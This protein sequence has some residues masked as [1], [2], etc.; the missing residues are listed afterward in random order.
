M[1]TTL[2]MSF[3]IGLVGGQ[4][5]FTSVD[6]D[7]IQQLPYFIPYGRSCVMFSC[8]RCTSLIGLV[9]V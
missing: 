9:L 4:L 1:D 2:A 6:D 7:D 8:I 3:G 5:C